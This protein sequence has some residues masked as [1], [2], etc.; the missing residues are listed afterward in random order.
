MVS[1]REKVDVKLENIFAVLCALEG[2]NAFISEKNT[3][4]C[5]S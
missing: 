5:L 1:L 2:I 3:E 4:E